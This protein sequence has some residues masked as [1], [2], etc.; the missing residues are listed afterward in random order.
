MSQTA[1]KSGLFRTI[2]IPLFLRH[3]GEGRNPC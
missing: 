2:T 3:S 1:K